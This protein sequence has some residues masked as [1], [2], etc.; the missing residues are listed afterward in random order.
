MGN[1]IRGKVIEK[2][3]YYKTQSNSPLFVPKSMVKKRKETVD[4]ERE[5]ER[6]RGSAPT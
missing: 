3:K 6:E 1:I 2:D 5:R 4:T